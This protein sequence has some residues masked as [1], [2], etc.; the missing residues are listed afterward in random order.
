MH[1]GRAGAGPAPGLGQVGE[2]GILQPGLAAAGRYQL[3]HETGHRTVVHPLPVGAL[4]HH[5][6]ED[7]GDAQDAGRERRGVGHEVEGIAA[8]VGLFV[9][10]GGPQGDLL[11]ATDAA[12]DAVG[13]IAVGVDDLALAGIEAARRRPPS[14]RR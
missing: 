14:A 7:V 3:G 1:G 4:L 12:Q 13:F 11:E 6:L 2:Q 10:A 8:A 5:R 9:V